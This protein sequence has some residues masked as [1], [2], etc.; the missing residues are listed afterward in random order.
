[1]I[2]ERVLVIEADAERART[3][4]SLLE[5]ADYPSL[6][7][8]SPD[9]A[10]W[11]QRPWLAALIGQQTCGGKLKSVL[12]S[13]RSHDAS[14]PILTLGDH[15]DVT[16]PEKLCWSLQPPVKY[17]HLVDALTRARRH[18][19]EDGGEDRFPVGQSAAI[20][21]LSRLLEQVAGFDSTVLVLGE[22]GVGKELVARRIH[23]LSPRRDA[24]F[25]PLNCG[26]IP[27][28]LLESELFGHEKGSF[29]GAISARAGRF[30]L[31]EGGTLFLDE[32]GDMTLPMQVKLLRVLQERTFER[33][34]STVQRR[35]DVRVVAATHRDLERR[36]ADGSFRE[37]LF[38]RLNVFPLRVPPLRE[39]VQDL[40]SLI[41]DLT[42]EGER[43]GRPTVALSRQATNALAGYQWP[44]NVRELANLLER[45]SILYPNRAVSLEDLPPR[46]RPG[47]SVCAGP[48]R[49]NQPGFPGQGVDLKAHLTSIERDLIKG[50]MEQANGTVAEAARLLSL[51]RTTLV[52]KLRK[53]QI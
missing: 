1:M 16:G 18:R 7:V 42:A 17:L 43:D 40:P 38:F 5:F 26:A 32:I 13:V 44:G 21:E 29:T 49:D 36:V 3:W 37:D 48:V 19:A 27:A 2:D 28:E 6:V 22:S 14:L 31:A 45:L 20:T 8:P 47:A 30:E 41:A 12:A 51:R 46:Y 15:A 23:Q 10:T 52:E 11:R 25:V 4:Q 24:P 53:Y 50:A 9:Q 39:R 35:A 33:V 34:G